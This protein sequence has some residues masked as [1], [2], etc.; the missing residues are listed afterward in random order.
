MAIAMFSVVGLI[1]S[2]RCRKYVNDFLFRAGFRL[3]CRPLSTVVTFHNL[4]YRPRNQGVC[5]ANHTSPYDIAILG[6]DCCYSLVR[7]TNNK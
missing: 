3:L 2:T 5:V 1:P 4:Q 6:V 7:L